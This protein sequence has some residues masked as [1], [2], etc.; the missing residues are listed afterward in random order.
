MTKISFTEG[1]EL[2][3]LQDFAVRRGIPA[4]IAFDVEALLVRAGERPGDRIKLRAPG[5]GYPTPDYGNG[6]LYITR[7]SMEG[8]GQHE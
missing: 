6:A 7:G 5:Y 8:K 2:L 1:N 3:Y 4:G